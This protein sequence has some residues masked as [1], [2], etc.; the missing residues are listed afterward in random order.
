MSSTY[1]ILGRP[2]PRVD[3]LDKVTGKAIYTA[4]ISFPGMLHL[5]VLRS[6][7]PHARILAIHTEKAKVYPGVVVVLTS[8]DIPGTNRTGPNVKDQPA[9]CEDKVRRVGDAVALVAAETPDIAAEALA[10]IDVDY[11]EL[12]GIFSFDEALE[13]EAV[14]IY[15]AG[16]LLCDRALR[17]GDS[18]QALKNA[19]VVI[20]NTYRTQMTE[21]AYMEPEAGVAVCEAGK[22]TV[23][24]PSKYA[25]SDQRQIAA[26]LGLPGDK[27]RLILPT[28]GGGFGDKDCLN[29][30]YYAALV[31]A[32]TGRPA[33]MVHDR[34]ESFVTS[35]KRHPFVID[36]TTGATRDGR[37]VAAKVD[38]RA[39]TGAYTS[40]GVMTL[41]RALIHA[42]GPYDIANVYVRARAAFTNNP[43]AGAMRGFGVP[44]V[45]VAHESQL[46]LLAEAL[47]LDPFEVRLKNGLKTG[48]CTATG[49]RLDNS[50][51]LAETLC[52]VRDEIAKRKV[53]PSS[54]SKKYGWGIASMFY[55]IGKTA[56]PNPGCA[57]MVAED[58]GEFALYVGCGDGGQGVQATMIQIAAETLQT[59]PDK[60][61]AILGD[62]DRCADAGPSS[63][64]RVTYVV[65]RAVQLTAERL[66]ESLTQAAAALLETNMQQIVLEHG[67]FHRSD[68][69]QR[70]LY[71]PEVV[72]YMKERGISTVAEASFNPATTALDA[73]TGQGIPYATYAFATQAA[74]V[75]ANLET[76]KVEVLS[77]VASHDVG[78]AV[79]PINAAAQIH[80]GVSMGVGYGLTEEVVVKN[81]AICN[82][83]FADYIV[84]T[85]MDM[86][87]ITTMLVE[88]EEPTGPFGAKGLGEPALLPTA[89]AILNAVAAATG[90]HAKETPIR[91]GT[92]LDLL[93]KKNY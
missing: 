51:G 17:K 30:G 4:D 82:P 92:L 69:P 59:T 48:S 20:T 47:K 41:M 28:I 75:E 1:Q 11:E 66:R 13:P 34:E 79:N 15:D 5:K 85:A 62:T 81:G 90:V 12:P 70:R 68:C 6:S 35:N 26:L 72:C 32:K 84:P 57:R 52:A 74:L 45:A 80:G 29:P 67:A 93:N 77:I 50:V 58:S 56:G 42:A 73:A 14:K 87:E 65:G 60:I 33:K 63:A 83:Q 9:L 61:H 21:H 55:G 64:S 22:V 10:L 76:G 27:V 71:L 36:Y 40:Y 46:D 18:D 31:S 24:M 91:C 53:P 7:L 78:R 2:L 86:P 38:I 3:V 37:I 19:D 44:Q 23:W 54:G 16:N 39:D 43:I 49:Q 8:R 89:P 88:S 25:H